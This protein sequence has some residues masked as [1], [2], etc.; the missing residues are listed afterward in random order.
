MQDY[1]V[2]LDVFTESITKKTDLECDMRSSANRPNLHGSINVL[3]YR[4]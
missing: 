1:F 2:R 3:F 4:V